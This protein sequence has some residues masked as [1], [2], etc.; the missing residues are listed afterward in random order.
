MALKSGGFV[1][2]PEFSGLSHLYEHM[3][4]KGNR[5][6]PNQEAYLDRLRELGALWNGIDVRPSA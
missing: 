1:E 3:F 2:T 5:V 6:I 4:F